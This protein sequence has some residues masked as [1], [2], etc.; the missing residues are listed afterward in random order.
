MQVVCKDGPLKGDTYNID[1]EEGLFR[2]VITNNPWYSFAVYSILPLQT[3]L[4]ERV[5]TFMGFIERNKNA[6][7]K[8]L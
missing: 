1:A 3:I 4:G 8:T 7:S 5:A 6:N 2:I